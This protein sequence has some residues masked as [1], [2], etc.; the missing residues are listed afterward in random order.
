MSSPTF[1]EIFNRRLKHRS[2]I[3]PC[4]LH[5]PSEV[6][7]PFSRPVPVFGSLRS[8]EP[9]QVCRLAYQGKM[10][11]WILPFTVI[12]RNA[13]I[14]KSGFSRAANWSTALSREPWKLVWRLIPFAGYTPGKN[15]AHGLPHTNQKTI[16]REAMPYKHRSSKAAESK[17]TMDLT[18]VKFLVTN[19]QKIC[20]PRGGSDT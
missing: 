8:G 7:S 19:K 18:L 9:F 6:S 17:K 15:P 1:Q 5:Q 11:D 16:T 13:M 12:A 14:P 10:D 4:S 2:R 20:I 3:Q